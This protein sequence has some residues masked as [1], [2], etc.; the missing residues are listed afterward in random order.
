[1]RGQLRNEIEIR[2]L[3]ALA[4]QFELTLIGVKLLDLREKFMQFEKER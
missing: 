2:K 3:W 4:S 1:M